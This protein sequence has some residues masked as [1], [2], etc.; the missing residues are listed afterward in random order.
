MKMKGLCRVCCSKLQGNQRRWI[1]NTCSKRRLQIV[2]S[3]V[4]GYTIRRDG[5]G[6]FLC[7]KC[8]F[9]LE[10]VIKYDI[11]TA[12]V[13]T[14]SSERLQ[15]LAAEKDQLIQCIVHLYFR[16]NEHSKNSC[17]REAGLSP[18][19]TDQPSLQYSL[20]LQDESILS[21]F[22]TPKK[23]SKEILGCSN[24]W[25]SFTGGHRKRW[26]LCS[27]SVRIANVFCDLVCSSP[28][29]AMQ[30]DLR[31]NVCSRSQ[32]Q[33]LCF[34][35]LPRS[36]AP[37]GKL[38]SRLC[39][40]NLETESAS[41][42]NSTRLDWKIEES[43]NLQLKSTFRNEEL[44]ETSPSMRESIANA[45]W[46]M[47]HVQYKPVASFSKS[48]IPRHVTFSALTPMQGC[49]I[50]ADF[51]EGYDS[52]T[53]EQ[54]LWVEPE[55]DFPF[56]PENLVEKHRQLAQLEV[57][58]K[59][60]KA[61]LEVAE[62]ANSTLQEKLKEVDAANEALQGQANEKINELAAEKQNSLK[63]DKT[64]QG[65]TLALKTKD[66][67]IKELYH[68][69]EER[70]N[71]LVKARDSI[72][73][74]QLQKFQ[75]AE[76]YQ[77]LMTEKETELAEIRADRNG[78]AMEVQKLQRAL[79]RREQELKDLTEAK[80]KLEEEVEELQLQKTKSD[81]TINDI[82]NHIQKLGAE[83]AEK[84]HAVEHQYQTLL[85]ENK[86]KLQ[87]QE[88]VI[89]RLTDSLNN[90]DRLLQ[91]YME[92]LKGVPQAGDQ[93]PGGK[94]ALLAK[95]RDRLREK[96]KA[97]EQALD[98]KH[99][100]IDEKE[101]EIQQLHLALREKEHNFDRLKSLLA[102][103]EE[104][105]NSLDGTIKE[106]DI[107]LQH[108]TN[109]CKSLQRLKQELEDS[110]VQSLREK[111]AVILQLQQSLKEKADSLE[112]MTNT[113]LSQSHCGTKDLAE[114]LNQRLK[115][116]EKL[117][118]NAWAERKKLSSEHEKE[119]EELLNTI[120][121]KDQ[122]L[123]E[124]SE[125]S[126]S[127]LSKLSH[128][129]DGLNRQN[130]EKEKP[131]LGLVEHDPMS[132]QDQILQIAQLK[133]ALDEKDK[134]INKLVEHGQKD[135]HSPQHEALNSSHV[136][137]LKQTIQILQEQLH[138]R[139]AELTQDSAEDEVHVKVP[140]SKKNSTNLKKELAQK[141]QEL[142]EALKRENDAKMEVIRLQ[143]LLDQLEKDAQI[144]AANVERLSKALQVK[145]EIIKN[146]QPVSAS[147]EIKGAEQVT[148]EVIV[149]KDGIQRP[150][151][152]PRERTIIGGGG[153]QPVQTLEDQVSEESLYQ[154]LKTEQQL[155]SGLIKAV[156]ES[157]S[158]N[159]I[160]A[161]QMELTGIQLLRQQLEES[162]Q[163]NR[164]LQKNLEQQ[165]QDAKRKDTVSKGDVVDFSEME[166]LRHQ[167]ED[168]R[169]WNVSLQSRLGQMQARAG[170]VGAA[171]DLG[172]TFTSCGDQ[173]S[174]LSICLGQFDDLEQEIV[175]LSLPELRQ[176]V[177]ELLKSLKALQANNQESQDRISMSEHSVLCSNSEDKQEEPLMAAQLLHQRQEESMKING[178]LQELSQSINQLDDHNLGTSKGDKC[179]QTVP[180]V[181]PAEMVPA[182]QASTTTEE[183]W[184]L[185]SALVF[186]VSA[187][188]RNSSESTKLF[189]DLNKMNYELQDKCRQLQE[190]KAQ[191]EI[192]ECQWHE[193]EARNH[194]MEEEVSTI[195]WLMEKN[196]VSSVTA[197]G[198][199]IVKLRAEITQL[200]DQLGENV[201]ISENEGEEEV[202]DE[203][204]GGL[205]KT[206][207]RLKIKLKKQRKAHDLLKQQ[208]ELNSSGEGA[209]FNPDLIV[210]MAKEIEH[211]KE[212]LEAANQKRTKEIKTEEG[213]G[214]QESKWPQSQPSEFRNHKA[215]S[216]EQISTRSRLPVP[217]KR[218]GSINSVNTATSGQDFPSDHQQVDQLRAAL[219][220]DKQLQSKLS[221][222]ETTL[223]NQAE[224]LRPH[225]TPIHAESS[226]KQD[227][228]EVQVDLQDLGYETCGKSDAD[229]DESGSP[230]NTGNHL[231]G[232]CYSDSA[233][234]ALLN[235]RFFS[236]ENLDT[237]SSTSYP[238]SPS[239]I[240]PKVSLKNLDVFDD[241][242]QTDDI[243]ELKLQIGELKEQIEKY[244][245]VIHHLQT[246]VRK[247]S[248]SSDQLTISDQSHQAPTRGSYDRHSL[249]S[250]QK[251]NDSNY[252]Q[253]RH[254][255]QSSDLAVQTSQ[256][257]GNL[258]NCASRSQSVDFG[259]Q[260]EK[261]DW[262]MSVYC[263]D[264]QLVQKL[265]EQMEQLED[266]IQKE[267]ARN[268]EL[269]DQLQSKLAPA[270]PAQKYDSLVQSQARELSHLRQQIKENRNIISLHRQ[271]LVDLTKAFE[272]LL[273]ASDVDY[274]VG[275]AFRD[276]LNQSLQLV[277]KL[278]SKFDGGITGDASSA[279]GDNTFV[280][281]SQ[282][283]RSLQCEILYLRKQLESERKHLH[284]RLNELLHENQA[285]SQATKEQ[286]AQ[287]AK[288]LQE[289]NKTIYYLQQQLHVPSI[290]QVA[291][292]SEISDR[293]SI[294]SH[295][296][297]STT[298]EPPVGKSSRKN[299][300]GREQ[301]FQQ[302]LNH[303]PSGGLP[304]TNS[305]TSLQSDPHNKERLRSGL[306]VS[307]CGTTQP[308]DNVKETSGS[309]VSPT[310][311][312][313]VGYADAQTLYELERE[314][315]AL[316]EQLM[317]KEELNE[318]LRTE[319]DLHRSIL[320]Q[321]QQNADNHA[322]F[323]PNQSGHTLIADKQTAAST[324]PKHDPGL[325][326]AGDLA[327][328][329]LEIRSLRQRLEESIRNND[330]LRQ[331]LECRLAA[332]END[333][334][335]TNIFIHGTDERSRMTDEVHYLK[336]Q[337]KT[338]KVQLTR[339]SR[340]KQRENEKLKES[341][342]KKTA[343]I[344]RLRSEC[345]RVKREST[346]L[347]LKVN[348]GHEESRKLKDELHCSREEISRLKRELN[349]QH[350][351]LAENQ[352][353]LQS[354]RVELRVYEQM[355]ENKTEPVRHE[356]HGSVK[357]FQGSVDL[358]ELMAEIRCLRI[359]LERSIQTNTALRQKLEEQL[360]KRQLRNEGSPS[361]ININYLLARG[362][363]SAGGRR[364]YRD[365]EADSSA[366]DGK[367]NF[368]SHGFPTPPKSVN[369]AAA[370][371]GS[372]FRIPG[373]EALPKDEFDSTSHYSES[374]VE[375]LSHRPSRFVPAR[376]MWADKDGQCVL[377]LLE[378][379]NAL[380]KQL[381]E[382]RSLLHGMDT[383][384]GDAA[385]HITAAVEPVEPLLKGLSS[386]VSTVQQVFEEAGRL[387]KLFWRV[388]LPIPAAS[389]SSQHQQEK[390]VKDEVSRL[391]KKLT[392]QEKLLHGTVK[393]LRTTNQLKEGME[394]III[395]QLSLT[396]DVLKKAR[397]NL[398][399]AGWR[400]PISVPDAACVEIADATRRGSAAKWE[401]IKS[402]D[403]AI[404]NS[405]SSE[406]ACSA[407]EEKN[408]SLTSSFCSY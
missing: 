119:I 15:M 349:L 136:L 377:G 222:D 293:I 384:L 269:T 107:E 114:H 326:G 271:S 292:D 31:G 334:A 171:N 361:T 297:H 304:A 324:E 288:E 259:S 362:Q 317:N 54:E 155:Y 220:D 39:T 38:A 325:H 280:D 24:C 188:D 6:E 133:A 212:H 137:E 369:V 338:L 169:R 183:N 299:R 10:K 312:W 123:R 295:E 19:S 239:L 130:V 13:K 53:S 74:A 331:Q 93:S 25:R 397:G 284:K 244:R 386:N 229:R 92:L 132:N 286:L 98:Q 250:F 28:R 290:S 296:G 141:S 351:L 371:D 48:K 360:Q 22:W 366:E 91:E 108:L 246:R 382:G 113:L 186:G 81:K 263:Q 94:D 166:C 403:G 73:K 401:L 262:L 314:N 376:R 7:S 33:S 261:G 226:L 225:C 187:A 70:D 8:A 68:E 300:S 209:R 276:Q 90:K 302:K 126:S 308:L 392:E 230:G 42:L 97:L 129:I 160:Q 106:K 55:H 398:E 306:G 217:L 76:E 150:G 234:P 327:G 408:D 44:T 181:E 365:S 353:L 195:R 127:R 143:A 172:N 341:L 235:R 57:E 51:Q 228:K 381:S 370:V 43:E 159:R 134:I 335:S 135:Q 255:I 163:T 69:I 340:D 309:Q 395:D 322:A 190:A 285:L 236:M 52:V 122:L 319:L 282:S 151:H 378:D 356:S 138:E 274:Y 272:E 203:S 214:L 243:S 26:C 87:S 270:L 37:V 165:I 145:D 257:V 131:A 175:N 311:D 321:R 64:I 1:F 63:R 161:L 104:T 182:Q 213:K 389:S 206:V 354:L 12:R 374:S 56:K 391:R 352:E 323:S 174:Y 363:R 139:D 128:D 17:D 242:G 101:N 318:T 95:L 358:N 348:N 184:K 89:E 59:Q 205:R 125:H 248:L 29:R 109:M 287:L 347:Q 147:S 247:N 140:R 200:R 394:K 78:K 62:T 67:E 173:T 364:L 367:E 71:A 273:Q 258:S 279:Y 224:K 388:S 211:L 315:S 103:R 11:V 283:P 30:G 251:D 245:K 149:L 21:E 158:R 204:K 400:A 157:D 112:E 146:I 111:D 46:E 218:P 164:D 88:L 307:S 100:A 36:P 344:E 18:E 14:V 237:N 77:S 277:E 144:Q 35:L 118:E 66:K 260:N 383:R 301:I 390:V 316:R 198:N 4:L 199:E 221:A 83:L 207:L 330:R 294:S 223:I 313:P 2:L 396:H 268:E 170:G 359:Q 153:Q 34:D 343:S 278:E 65:L 227:D 385:C 156:K 281:F 333:L 191:L 162:I 266:Q 197:L 20:L 310:S 216:T 23:S 177:I 241:Y 201:S 84:E 179:I 380:H 355:K 406:E 3:Y 192:T 120:N 387:L 345:E 256:Q 337:N 117:L 368:Q 80:V 121:S 305:D 102:N 267:R 168:A 142:D 232:H 202:D 115:V 110:Q 41:L 291:S 185:D 9:M 393:R 265:K 49:S 336:E 194:E 254:S 72:H 116:Q 379:Y 346:Q 75:G 249:E 375:N 253:R 178:G 231:P 82:Q 399:V 32:S 85:T 215:R 219:K 189:D 357:H 27:N 372:V 320:T 404:N 47:K 58:V 350:Q 148:R 275:E 5:Q 180:E 405:C 402:F 105:I 208:I 240:S 60:L 342:S 289:K 154:A 252:S 196:G 329:L 16:Y 61:D 96:D 193:M 40:S 238:S 210:S 332:A 86:Q 328:H 99:A 373:I 152:L 176:K 298:P 407:S 339:S 264:G 45:I 233:V 79:S 50:A 124:A 303:E 167:L